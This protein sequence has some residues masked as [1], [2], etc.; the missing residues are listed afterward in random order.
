MLFYDFFL[1]IIIYSPTASTFIGMNRRGHFVMTSID[2]ISSISL[3]QI[4]FSEYRNTAST[5]LVTWLAM[6][7]GG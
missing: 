1:F 5:K 6:L 3:I 7:V 2:H 4:S